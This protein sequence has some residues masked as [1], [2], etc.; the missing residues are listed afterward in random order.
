MP[1]LLILISIW[2]FS[3]APDQDSAD[4]TVTIEL[5]SELSEISGLTFN[6]TYFIGINDSGNGPYIYFLDTTDFSIVNKIKLSGAKN[7]DWEE[8]CYYDGYLYLGNF[9]NNFGNRKDLS[10]YRVKLSLIESGEVPFEEMR[11]NYQMQKQHFSNPY[12]H[13]YDCEAF[14]VDT[15]GIR[16][17]SKDWANRLCRMYRLPFSTDNISIVPVDSVNLGFLV[18]GSFF[19]NDSGRLFLCGYEDKDTFLVIF[20]NAVEDRF[21]SEFRKYNLPSL[22]NLQ[23]ESIFVKDNLIYLASERTR[24]RQAVYIMPVPE[25]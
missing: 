11:I 23:V 20:D 22:K 3:C 19:D 7:I 16:L 21:S 12:M 14:S 15:S 5:D 4:K 13:I 8:A 18:T 25:K 9:G 24:I 17:Y 10:I 1:S 6:G 2:L